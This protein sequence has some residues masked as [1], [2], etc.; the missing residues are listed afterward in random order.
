MPVRAITFDFWGTL[1]QD[2]NSKA[3]RRIRVDAFAE[4]T[5]AAKSDV[6]TALEKAMIVFDRC[7]RE[8]QRTLRPIDAVRLAAQNLGVT[9]DTRVEQEMAQIFGEAILH[10]EPAPIPGA[11]DAVRAA[12][13][14][15]PVGVLSD[16]G[17]SP[18]SSLRLL[19]QRHGFLQYMSHKAVVFSDDVGVAKP[20]RP[21]FEAVISA[22]AVEASG[23]L[24]IGDLEYTDIAG[25]RAFGAKTALF[26]GVNAK[27]RDGTAADFVFNDWGEFVDVLP[28][29]LAPS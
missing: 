1:F 3:R 6:D 22:L 7:H 8:E 11:L 20:Q 21:M 28:C 24:H 26:A 4:A 13:E 2:A 16:A 23:L 25:G 12:A 27:Y 9:V 5:G 18:G 10:H 17:L 29:L 19:L 15:V 14:K